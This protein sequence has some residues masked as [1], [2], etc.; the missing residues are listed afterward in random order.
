MTEE[1][2]EGDQKLGELLQSLELVDAES[3]SS[4]LVEARKQRR[5]L[6]QMLLASGSVTL[7][8]MAM[9]EAGNFDSLVL[10]PVRV[11]DRLRVT[12]HETVYRVFDPRRD[13]A[14]EPGALATGV[15]NSFP[16]SALLR[17]LSESAMSDAAW[18]EEFRTG[19]SAACKVS[20]PNLAATW[21]VLDIQG[22]PAVLQEWLTGL[23]SSD[24]PSLASVGS[25]WFRLLRQAAQGMHAA[26]TAGMFHG[27]LQ[28]NR[29]L[30]TADG[31]VKIAGFGEP[32]WLVPGQKSE[33][34]SQ[35]SG[36]RGQESEV[37]IAAGDHSPEI[38]DLGSLTSA[39]LADLCRIAAA[40]A[41]P[42][43][44]K[45]GTRAKPFP[46]ALRKILDRLKAEDAETRYPSAAA[47]LTDLDDAADHV[48][49]NPE[50]WDKLLSHIRDQGKDTGK[51]EMPMKKSA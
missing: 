13:A 4:L 48:S 3:L 31:V 12:A 10:G 27:H 44:K 9:I 33:V 1:I 22:R 18:V 14:S 32:D 7:Y 41:A 45:K 29:I 6:R 49:D 40:W 5:S 51:E 30:L 28:A 2:D 50:A 19:F 17:H 37:M 25:V 8:Q 38:S 47:L 15:V 11:L 20:H 21:E 23:P 26:H 24:W 16:G 34:R 43:A 36:V 39:D 46:K 35:G 42:S